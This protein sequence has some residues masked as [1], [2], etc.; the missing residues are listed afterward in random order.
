MAYDAET[1]FDEML[2]LFRANLNTKTAALNAEKGGDSLLKVDFVDADF[3]LNFDEQVINKDTF[4]YYNFIDIATP[5]SS[6]FCVSQQYKMFFSIMEI[7][8]DDETLELKKN[9]ALY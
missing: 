9:I 5:E 3:V 4:V 6:A 2:A 1:F 8:T 7:C